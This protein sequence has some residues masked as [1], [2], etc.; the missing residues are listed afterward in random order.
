MR[1]VFN[2]EGFR[3][4]IPSSL[5]SD[6]SRTAKSTASESFESCESDLNE[7]FPL[8]SFE[9]FIYPSRSFLPYIVSYK[10]FD[11]S[12]QVPKLD[13]RC[14]ILLFKII[15][16]CPTSLLQLSILLP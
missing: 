1:W 11:L 13:K 5:G 14:S 4:Q 7:C 3:F 9:K 6:E 12:S 15:L 16:H 10:R 8:S 2:K